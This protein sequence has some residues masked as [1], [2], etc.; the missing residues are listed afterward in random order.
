MRELRTKVARHIAQEE[1]TEGGESAAL[2]ALGASND[3]PQSGEPLT[4]ASGMEAELT[5]HSPE[6]PLTPCTAPPRSD[7]GSRRLA[8]RP[9]CTCH[10]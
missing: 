4:N 1:S 3:E 5:G 6:P 8:S 9:T 2:G 10:L 7:H